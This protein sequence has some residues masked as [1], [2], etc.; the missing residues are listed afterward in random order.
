VPALTMC[1]LQILLLPLLSGSLQ[2][3]RPLPIAGTDDVFQYDDGTAQ[4]LT[5]TGLYRG[6][7]FNW[8]DFASGQPTQI[9][10]LEFWFF[11]H[12]SYPWDTSSFWGE[13]WNGGPS[14]PAVQLDQTSVAATHYAP[15]YADYVWIVPDVNFW[16]IV[17]TEMSSGG[18]PAL[19]GDNTPQPVSHSLFS[20]DFIVWQ[21]WIIQGPTA[22]DFLIRACMSAGALQESTWGSIK[23]LF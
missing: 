3:D 21:P 7:W 18:W 11:H 22:N 14:G 17:N 6:V 13:L 2:L 8:N 5:W 1:A 23:T 15:C 16:G 9:F 10:D 19:L 20:D 4:W 12:S